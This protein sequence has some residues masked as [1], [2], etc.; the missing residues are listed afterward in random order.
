MRRFTF[1]AFGDSGW[2]VM[3]VLVAG[4]AAVCIVLLYRY[5]R[6]LVPRRLGLTLLSLRLAVVG[7]VFLTLLEPVL[8][9]TIDRTRTGRVLI[10]VDVSDSMAT[11]DKQA[12]KSERLRWLRALKLIG[13]D[14]INPRLDR[15]QEAFDNNREPEWVDPEETAD[16]VERAELA[17]V[18]RQQLDELMHGIEE[19]TRREIARRLIDSGPDALRKRVEKLA[20]TELQVFAGQAVTADAESLT[21]LVSHPD[22]SLRPGV[23]DLYTGIT[24]AA[25]SAEA[26][27]TGVV[28]FT[29]GR[30]NAALD[31]EQLLTRVRGLPVP[32]YPVLMGSQ[33]RPRD[34]AVGELEYPE[35]VYQND[36]ALL[37]AQVRTPGFAGGELTV[38]LQPVDRPDQAQ[39]RTIN[40][41]DRSVDVEFPLDATELGRRRYVLRIEPQP[42]ETR[43]DNNEK[44][45]VVNVVDDKSY[46]LVLDGAARWEFRFLDNA[47]TRD[48]RV[49][50]DRVVF[51]QPSLGVLPETFFPQTLN[52]PENAETAA[53]SPFADYDAIV[54]GD[55]PPAYLPERVWALLDRFVRDQGG[56]LVL[57]AGKDHFP[58]A[59]TS[60]TVRRLLPVEQ[61][62][63]LE[64]SGPQQSGPPLTRGFHLLLTPEGF[65][66]EFLQFAADAPTNIGIWNA[67][68]GHAWGLP[69][70]AKPEA[71]VFAALRD[72]AG[73]GGLDFERGNA[74]IA[75][76]HTGAGQVLWIGIDSTWRWRHRVGDQYHHRFWGQI[77]RWAAKFKASAGN[78]HCRFGPERTEIAAGEDVLLRA[79][80]NQRFLNAFP[81]LKAKA[82]LTA[83]DA[84]D[85]AEPVATVKLEPVDSWPLVHEGKV[86]ALKT[87]EYRVELQVEDADLGDE[88]VSAELIVSAPGTSELAELSADRNLLEQIAEATGGRLF[89]PDEVD[90]IPELF[91]GVTEHGSS[92]EE[93][94]LWDH[95]LMLALCFGLL[96][97]EWVL[98]K[99]NGLP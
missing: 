31:A 80:W 89:L 8:T 49:K 5:E 65:R 19:L 55:V 25:S 76:Q 99:L 16:P 52:L 95:W 74:L 75:H 73:R 97:T 68:P 18:R 30:D 98:R 59:Y 90:K 45:F 2:P 71:T 13:N 87:G 26:P 10:A 29:D 42:G 81:N 32:V 88:P 93:I 96:T 36:A 79:I 57:T 46:V 47:L 34:L 44:A 66:Q 9:W 69:G 7:T 15:W 33:Q 35:M 22:E 20:V 14:A 1:N 51:Q 63:V 83:A 17:R 48:P 64:D 60:Q 92:R 37:K 61:P 50:V 28:L 70:R 27:L 82:V 6:R 54:I 41:A 39:S 40:A 4:A 38:T 23:S 77:A 21:R 86:S 56:T 62:R 67:L 3:L 43:A 94:A 11:A 84:G 78:E 72:E 91:A 12:D 24:P 58:R 53:E 85:G